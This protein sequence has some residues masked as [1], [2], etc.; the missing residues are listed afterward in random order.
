M[1]L[2]WNFLTMFSARWG[3]N[4]P[5]IKSNILNP[6]Y[7]MAHLIIWAYAR[8]SR[9]RSFKK[10][11]TTQRKQFCEERFYWNQPFHCN[12]RFFFC[13]IQTFLSRLNGENKRKP[14]IYIHRSQ[15]NYFTQ[16][17]IFFYTSVVTNDGKTS[18]FQFI[19]KVN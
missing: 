9:L 4:C 8:W 16:I 2:F 18:H 14:F 1:W 11:K 5:W 3:L 19:S 12:G 7:I 17:Y 15:E 6:K 10:V 13:F